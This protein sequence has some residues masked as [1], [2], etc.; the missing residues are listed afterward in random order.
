MG[1]STARVYHRRLIEFLAG[2]SLKTTTTTTYKR[3][4]GYVTR[5]TT[6]GLKIIMAWHLLTNKGSGIA[7]SSSA[8]ATQAMLRGGRRRRVSLDNKRGSRKAAS[9]VGSGDGSHFHWRYTV[10]HSLTYLQSSPETGMET[11]GMSVFPCV[12]ATPSAE[13][14]PAT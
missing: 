1:K 8:A 6:T 11:C 12:V 2:D 10:T 5:I 3:K 7:L 4:I 9:L 13:L 14:Y